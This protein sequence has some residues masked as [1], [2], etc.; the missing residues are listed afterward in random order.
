MRSYSQQSGFT[1]VELIITLVISMIL[2][3]IVSQFITRP[4]QAYAD[5]EMRARLVSTAELTLKQ[6]QHDIRG[7]VPNSPRVA[8]GGLCIEFLSLKTSGRYRAQAP[9]DPLDFN[10]S[11]N[12]TTF[13][14]LSMLPSDQAVTTS[15]DPDACQNGTADCLVVYNTG[16]AGS[17]AFNLDNAA[18][19]N[20]VT[21]ASPQVI[22]FDNTRFA[23][24]LN[25]FPVPS[26][27][28]HFAISDG[29]VTYLCDTAAGTLRKYWDYPIISNQT[30]VD[31]AAELTAYSNTQEA[32]IS[33]HVSN[34]QFT[35][36]PGSA[37]HSSLVIVRLQ[38]SDQN[39]SG[40]TERIQLLKQIHVSNT[41]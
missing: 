41:P 9:G 26:P 13:E 8:C 37:T 38:I 35:Y 21:S 25:A 29:P 32:L 15:A 36:A 11:A 22:I 18:T 23:N 17:N 10:P 3:G 20:A 1:L 40:S 12:D 4:V 27:H 2:S 34:C 28:Q 7:A 14:V 16:L 30:G 6:F 24:S 33:K 5:Q 39:A 19:I 31:T